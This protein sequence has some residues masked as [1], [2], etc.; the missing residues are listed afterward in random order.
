M[1]THPV[2]VATMRKHLAEAE[3]K[4]AVLEEQARTIPAGRRA[5]PQ[6]MTLSKKIASAH[7]QALAWRR[8][9]ETYGEEPEQ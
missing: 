1:S 2:V 4:A 7:G 9:L 3:L 8:A 5:T 6:S